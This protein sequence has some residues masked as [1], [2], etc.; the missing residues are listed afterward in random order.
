[1][2]P[3]V[4]NFTRP[5]ATVEIWERAQLR[6]LV[7][8]QQRIEQIARIRALCMLQVAILEV[9]YLLGPSV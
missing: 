4:H 5:A 6:C 2:M 9:G 3:L 7:K 1:M 8:Y